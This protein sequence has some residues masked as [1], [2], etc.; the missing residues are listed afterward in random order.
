MDL[1]RLRSLLAP[2]IAALFIL[3]TLCIFSVQSSPSTGFKI[4]ILKISHRDVFTCDGDW[5]FVQLLDDGRTKI[6][7]KIIREE[8]LPSLVSD[9]M[10]SRAERLIYVVPSSGMPYSRPMLTLSSLKKAVPDMHIGVLTGEA[11]DAY[12]HPHS[13]CF[14]AEIDWPSGDF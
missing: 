3:L 1:L 11:R 8:E 6:N 7:G 5:A 10:A 4:P 14:P 9:V 12:M 13:I 2:P